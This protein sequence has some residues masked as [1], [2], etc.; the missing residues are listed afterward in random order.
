MVFTNLTFRA[1]GRTHIASE[2]CVAIA[3]LC[4]DSTVG[5]PWSVPVLKQRLLVRHRH[6][7]PVEGLRGTR[8]CAQDGPARQTRGGAPRRKPLETLTPRSPQPTTRARTRL[9][10]S[11]LMR[12]TPPPLV[13]GREKDAGARSAGKKRVPPHAPD[14]DAPP[15]PPP[16]SLEDGDAPDPRRGSATPLSEPLLLP[17]LRS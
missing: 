6:P 9:L 10:P 2:P 1:L 11:A 3:M 14:H 16:V 15:S 13:R 5:F 17:K 4:F 8:A 12:R 7:Y